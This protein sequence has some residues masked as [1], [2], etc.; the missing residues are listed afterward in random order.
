MQTIDLYEITGVSADGNRVTIGWTL[1]EPV[2]EQYEANYIVSHDPVAFELPETGGYH[3]ADDQ[4]GISQL[5]NHEEQPCDIVVA[6][7]SGHPQVI[8]GEITLP[9][10]H[11]KDRR[12]S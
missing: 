3:V 5:Y 1:N 2:T 8:D 10:L 11:P 9:E 4:E 7:E 6:K 12:K